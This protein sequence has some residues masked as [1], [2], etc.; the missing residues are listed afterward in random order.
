MRKADRSA[1]FR[2]FMPALGLLLLLYWCTTSGISGLKLFSASSL[3]LSSF[4]YCFVKMHS[5]SKPF[6]AGSP[7]DNYSFSYSLDT[8]HDGSKIVSACSSGAYELD[9][10]CVCFWH[11]G[12]KHFSAS[13]P[14]EYEWVSSF[15]SIWHFGWKPFSA[16]SPGEY[17]WTLP[18]T[19]ADHGLYSGV[20]MSMGSSSF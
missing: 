8:R 1:C 2:V 12:S 19:K 10:S 20:P 13:S 9:S 7:G 3:E 5:G 4:C 15:F 14:G 16:G 6:S 18:C 17:S 11:S